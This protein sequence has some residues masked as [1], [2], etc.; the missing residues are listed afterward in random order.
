[1][2]L[3]PQGRTFRDAPVWTPRWLVDVVCVNLEVGH[4]V[5]D[6]FSVELERHAGRAEALPQ[7]GI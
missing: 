3:I 2:I 1:M 4:E 7:P 6:R 5:A